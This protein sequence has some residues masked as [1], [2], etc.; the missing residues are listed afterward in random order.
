MKVYPCVAVN[1]GWI[2]V[3][4]LAVLVDQ[5]PTQGSLVWVHPKTA[6][7]TSSTNW[8]TGECCV[9]AAL[10]LDFF[11]LTRL[12]TYFT[13]MKI[14]RVI[15]SCSFKAHSSRI[16]DIGSNMKLCACFRAFLYDLDKNKKKPPYLTHANKKKSGQWLTTM[17]KLDTN[18]FEV[19]PSVTES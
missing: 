3:L 12:L 19:H 9:T 6:S 10:V 7:T 13:V 2:Q 1:S 14:G 5:N 18:P 4:N 16:H 11:F 15:I 8:W 17:M